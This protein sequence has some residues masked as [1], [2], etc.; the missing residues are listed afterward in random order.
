VSTQQRYS[1]LANAL[2]GYAH[3]WIATLPGFE[4]SFIPMEKI[5]A[6]AGALSKFCVDTIDQYDAKNPPVPAPTPP[7]PASTPLKRGRPRK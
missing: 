7:A 1:F 4:Q 2:V 3:Q 6:A 5:P